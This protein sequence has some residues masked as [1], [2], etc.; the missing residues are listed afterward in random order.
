[1]PAG[2]VIEPGQDR[3]P[4]QW[5]QGLNPSPATH[6]RVFSELSRLREIAFLGGLR[7]PFM[8]KMQAAGCAFGSTCSRPSA[9]ASSTGSPEAPPGG[10]AVSF[11]A[12]AADG[13]PIALSALK[14]AG[15]PTAN[16]RITGFEGALVPRTEDRGSL[17]VRGRLRGSLA[18]VAPCR[19]SLPLAQWTK[20]MDQTKGG[21]TGIHNVGGLYPL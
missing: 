4:G 13:I 16:R 7:C 2:P 15:C 12:K 17:P 21:L 20:P 19:R 3:H 5:T 6:G 18:G 9:P 8:P 14:A 1:M 11:P 10:L